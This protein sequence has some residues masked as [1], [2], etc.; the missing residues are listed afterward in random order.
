[1]T[2]LKPR[3]YRCASG[4]ACG[5]RKF[6]RRRRAW[7]ARSRRMQTH[8]GFFIHRLNSRNWSSNNS[9]YRSL[10]H[11]GMSSTTPQVRPI[12]TSVRTLSIRLF[13]TGKPSHP[14]TV[15]G[16]IAAILPRGTRSG[17]RDTYG[18]ANLS[19]RGPCGRRT[20]RCRSCHGRLT[21]RPLSSICR[22]GRGGP[23]RSRFS[24]CS[25]A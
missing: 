8:A 16:H 10:H 24:N 3:C 14:K 19:G 23:D 15:P 6:G 21:G 5:F 17:T 25:S 12:M 20:C 13:C 18:A 1:M 11:S 7:T 2:P 9:I 22:C 4:P